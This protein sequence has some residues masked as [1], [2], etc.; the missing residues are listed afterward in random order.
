MTTRHNRATIVM[1]AYEPTSALETIARTLSHTGRPVI[2]VDDGSPASCRDLFAR[3][4]RL[5]GVVLLSHEVN[6]GKG[7]AL[8][9]AFSYCLRH[10]PPDQAGVVTA[11]ADGQHAVE[12]IVRVADQ[13]DRTPSALVL[14]CR[15]FDGAV[16]LRSRVGN[17]VASTLFRLI[18]GRSLRDTQTGLRGIPR[19]FV[20]DLVGIEAGRY[21][22]ELDM[23][24]RAA[25][26]GMAIVQVPIRTIY[27]G[28]SR[29][30]FAPLRDSLRVASVFMRAARAARR[31]G[32]APAIAPAATDWEAYHHR[33]GMFT[34][35]TRRY[36]ERQIVRA[37]SR[38]AV[39]PASILEL[40][41]GNS[42]F[43]AALHARFPRSRLA[44]LD[45]S[46]TGLQRLR[47]Q[48][49]AT[50][51]LTAVA[52]S[53]LAPLDDVDKADVVLSIGLI[54]HFDREGTARAIAA[55]F[56]LARPGGVVLLTF[57]T[58]TW[59]YRFTRHLA[60]RTGTW[61]FP[62][63]RPLEFAEVSREVSRHGEILDQRIH[64]PVVLTQGLIVARCRPA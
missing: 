46:A 33:P 61:A 16:P 56:G 15:Q 12:D 53:V 2:V 3:V 26:R 42:R 25:A 45:T 5:P 21:E 1:P 37:V 62:D 40:G 6:R 50:A 32:P 44:A 58:P 11:D 4:A 30:H 20:G 54:E 59:L 55:H 39:G 27:G 43:L 52:R 31:A 34:P 9:T 17:L 64:W 18:L 38:F 22:F 41:G 7:E 19:N 29:L 23:L 47:D 36:T 63:E 57:P 14:G 8:K 48:L 49:P 10:G 24:V 60:E 51:A 13:L 28:A 35:L